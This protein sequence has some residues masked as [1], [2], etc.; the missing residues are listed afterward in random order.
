MTKTKYSDL[1]TARQHRW[2]FYATN[3]PNRDHVFDVPESSEERRS[4]H[5]VA[6]ECRDDIAFNRKLGCHSARAIYLDG[7]RLDRGGDDIWA[8]RDI[9]EAFDDGEREF[10]VAAWTKS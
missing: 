4:L 8:V 9:L 1:A 7:K 3:T 5:D 10:S 6:A 2:G